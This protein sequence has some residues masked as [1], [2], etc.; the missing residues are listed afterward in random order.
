MLMSRT[1]NICEVCGE[2]RNK[3]VNSKCSRI[4][5]KR[6]RDP[7]YIAERATLLRNIRDEDLQNSIKK[8]LTCRINA[9]INN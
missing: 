8:S 3:R 9:I 4:L 5:Q 6:S 2:P 7:K 1:F